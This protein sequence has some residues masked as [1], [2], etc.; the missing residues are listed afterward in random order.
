MDTAKLR[1]LLSAIE[2]GSLSSAGER[3]GYTPSGI[4]RAV[5]ALEEETGFPLLRRGRRGVAPTE[6]CAALLPRI[7]ALLASEERLLQDAA[8]LRGL[9]YGS[10][11]IGCA[12]GSCYRFYLAALVAE[13]TRA[14]PGV[15]VDLS[16]GASSALAAAL[17]E[18]RGDLCLISRREGSFQ[19]ISLRSDRLVAVLPADHPLAGAAAYP[20]E[21][22]RDDAFIEI[23]PGVET[24]NSRMLRALGIRPNT[25]FTCTDVFSAFSMA[26]AGLGVTLADESHLDRWQGRTAALPLSPPQPVELGIAIPSMEAA[27]PA[28]RAF[29]SA[30]LKRFAPCNFP[31]PMA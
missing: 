12:Y 8:A 10:L 14:H 15:R 31:P 1:I 24:D 13:F 20:V 22:F 29:L 23:L 6:A 28:A 7:R 21:R 17:E 16:E 30:L 18:G 4:S 19:W 27:S 11:A 25:R 3:E 5:A 26:E 9:E 2:E